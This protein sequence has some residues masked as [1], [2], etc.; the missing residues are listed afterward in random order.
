MPVVRTT[1]F[2]RSSCTPTS[3]QLK[4]TQVRRGSGPCFASFHLSIIILIRKR[5]SSTFFTH[6]EKNIRRFRAGCF[7]YRITVSPFTVR[8]IAI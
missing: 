3:V 6:K 2:R 7:L 5:L 1:Y 4:D 8:V